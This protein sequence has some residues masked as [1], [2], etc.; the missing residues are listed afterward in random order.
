[1]YLDLKRYLLK[2]SFSWEELF[3][4]KNVMYFTPWSWCSTYLIDIGLFLQ[5]VKTIGLREIWFFGLQYVDSKG[6]TTWLK[7]IW[8][9]DITSGEPFFL[10]I[11]Y[12][13][14]T[15]G[16]PFSLSICYMDIT[17]L[18]IEFQP[19]GITLRRSVLEKYGSLVYSMLTVKVIPHGWNSIKRFVISM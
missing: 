3:S 6:Y 18:F 10:S 16:G 15:S 11:C 7:L 8:Y 19:C 2:K 9:M 14:I 1:M 4:I 12:M 5:V 17:N 13:D